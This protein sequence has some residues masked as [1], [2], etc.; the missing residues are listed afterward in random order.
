MVPVVAGVLNGHGQIGYD[1]IEG[2]ECGADLFG[3]EAYN[4]HLAGAVVDALLPQ[5]GAR[6]VSTVDE[7]LRAIEQGRYRY[8]RAHVEADLNYLR[9]LVVFEGRR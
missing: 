4:N 9:S 8:E 1:D 7:L 3:T 5:V 2:C 6:I